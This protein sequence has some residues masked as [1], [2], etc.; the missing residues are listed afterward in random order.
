[1]KPII[2]IAAVLGIFF[3]ACNKK[4]AEA[5]KPQNHDLSAME[6]KY[7]ADE[8]FSRYIPMDSANKMLSSYL[9]SI[10]AN[11]ND[12]DL[13]A[14][15]YNADTL[16]DYLSN[17]SIKYVKFMLAHTL[18]YINEG[19]ANQKA[20]YVAGNLTI[21]IAGFDEQGNYIYNKGNLVP[22]HGMPCPESCPTG[23]AGGNYLTY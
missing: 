14:I 13:R 7:P 9:N 8:V 4:E 1:M 10:N 15:I 21:I 11:N 5:P 22:D 20:G 18:E 2:A 16:R 17:A 19:H 6:R 3:V 12:S 23:A